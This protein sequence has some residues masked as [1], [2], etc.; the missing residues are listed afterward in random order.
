[1]IQEFLNYFYIKT[2]SCYIT[3]EIEVNSS[4]KN[5]KY[6]LMH[7]GRNLKTQCTLSLEMFKLKM[8][9]TFTSLKIV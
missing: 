4:K 3:F 1:M 5:T 8:V 6:M 2:F 9:K 7:S